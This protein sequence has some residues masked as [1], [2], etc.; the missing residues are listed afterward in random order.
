M[1]LPQHTARLEKNT[2]EPQR[3]AVEPLNSPHRTGDAPGGVVY[4]V[5]DPAERAKLRAELDAMVAHLYGLTDEQ[6]AHVLETFPLVDSSVRT[7]ALNEFV[8]MASTGEAAVFNPELAKPAAAASIDPAA[9]TKALI[10]Q[11]ESATLEFKSTA[12][13]NVKAGMADAKMER[14]I[15]KTVAAF[16]NA[17]GGTLIIGLE[18]DGRVYGLHEDYKLCGNKGRDG[19]ENWLMQ[20]LMKDFNKDVAAQLSA[21]FHQIG[22][23]DAAKPGSADVCV[24]RVEPSPRPRFAQENNQEV[25]YVRTGNATNQL[26][27]S[28]FAAYSKQRWPE[29]ANT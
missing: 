16:L 19:F 2:A 24:V 11:G 22:T 9:V 7:A 3:R 26:K 12:R 14:V 4:G 13:W 21:E 25:F 28:E 6:F 1:E 17:K 5:T 18:D 20:T 15:V 23:A 27:M 10:A 29:V 8:R